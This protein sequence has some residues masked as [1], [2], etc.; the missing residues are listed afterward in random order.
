MTL[1]RQNIATGQEMTPVSYMREQEVIGQLNKIKTGPPA[2]KTQKDLQGSG[3]HKDSIIMSTRTEP[4]STPLLVKYGEWLVE[5]ESLPPKEE[6]KTPRK[7]TPVKKEKSVNPTTKAKE[8]DISSAATARDG[9]AVEIE[10][11]D[12][13]KVPMRD[14]NPESFDTFVV[15]AQRLVLEKKNREERRGGAS[16]DGSGMSMN[17]KRMRQ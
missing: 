6:A 7:E 9:T 14:G 8:L 2:P 13:E 1:K 3:Q 16:S 17:D 4:E 10:D 5:Q 11:P 15:E 12:E